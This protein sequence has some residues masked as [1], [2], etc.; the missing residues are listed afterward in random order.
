MNFKA[1]TTLKELKIG[2]EVVVISGV[3]GEE[4]LYRIMINQSFKGYIQKRMGE[5]YRVDGSSIHDLIFAR[6]AN[7]MMS[8]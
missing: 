5:F 7:F 6:I 2:S 3:K 1:A 8:E 4:G